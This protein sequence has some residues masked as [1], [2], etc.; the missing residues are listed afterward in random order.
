MQPYLENRLH[1]LGQNLHLL[2]PLTNYLF[3]KKQLPAFMQS[4]DFSPN[5]SKYFFISHPL[6]DL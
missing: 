2:C 4:F 5:I 1:L 6:S 3:L